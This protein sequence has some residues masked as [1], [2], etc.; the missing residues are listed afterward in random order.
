MQTGNADFIYKNDLDKACFQHG[1]AYGK[2]TESDNVWRDKVFQIS[3][4]PKYDGYLSKYCKVTKYF[5]V[6]LI[7]L[8]NMDGLFL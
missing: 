6:R 4:D 1:M 3:I 5:Y 2:W 7:R 8:V